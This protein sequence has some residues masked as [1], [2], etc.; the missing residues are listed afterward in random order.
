MS[1]G[2]R[3][4]RTIGTL[5]TG[6]TVTATRVVWAADHATSWSLEVD[7][8]YARGVSD[9]ETD[10]HLLDVAAAYAADWRAYDARAAEL[11][12]ISAYLP[13][14]LEPAA[15]KLT[16]DDVEIGQVVWIFSRGNV[17]RGEVVKIGRSKIHVEYVSSTGQ[18]T[19]KSDDTVWADEALLDV[20]SAATEEH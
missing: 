19:K 2:T 16:V 17:R 14:G 8:H 4:T 13:R 5:P 15:P 1:T 6:E 3:E 18:I 7:G 20:K 9:A 12:P 10:D 11:K